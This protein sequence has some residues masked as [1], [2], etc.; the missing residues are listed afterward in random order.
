MS[1][2]L[3][4]NVTPATTRYLSQGQNMSVSGYITF[5]VANFGLNSSHKTLL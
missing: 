1:G 3:T 4:Q 5:F 2:L